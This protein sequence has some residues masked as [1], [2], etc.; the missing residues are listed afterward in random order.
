[1]VENSCPSTASVVEIGQIGKDEHS[2]RSPEI[3]PI[4]KEDLVIRPRTNPTKDLLQMVDGL[5]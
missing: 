2:L 5:I 3:F 4:G 1:M